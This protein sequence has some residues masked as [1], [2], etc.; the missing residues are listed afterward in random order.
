[1]AI[2]T[3]RLRLFRA[4]ALLSCLKVVSMYA[5]HPHEIDACSV[6]EAAA[7]LIE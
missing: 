2:E 5:D 1:M 3:Q 7:Q 6:A 4:G